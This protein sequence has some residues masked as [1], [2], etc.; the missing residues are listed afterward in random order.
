MWPERTTKFFKNDSIDFEE[1]DCK[2][3]T[4]SDCW[5]PYVGTTQKLVSPRLN[6]T[7]PE[8]RQYVENFKITNAQ[9]YDIITLRGAI[10]DY[11]KAICIYLE[12]NEWLFDQILHGHENTHG[13]TVPNS[14]I[15][16]SRNVTFSFLKY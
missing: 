5:Y 13:I 7:M 2:Y 15:C 4:I 3:M 16:T 9:M 11:E 6:S 10:H 1:I 12:Q 8:V 14:V